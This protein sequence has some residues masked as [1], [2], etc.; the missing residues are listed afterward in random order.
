M[1]VLPVASEVF[2]VITTFQGKNKTDIIDWGT[3]QNDKI[4]MIIF[5]Q[6]PLEQMEQLE[7]ALLFSP[8]SMLLELS[9]SIPR[10]LLLPRMPKKKSRM[11]NDFIAFRQHE[12]CKGKAILIVLSLNSFLSKIHIEINLYDCIRMSHCCR[13][14]IEGAEF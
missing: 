6:L 13:L 12:N 2:F 14:V 8:Q 9:F 1:I 11:G 3:N 4:S 7:K 5:V 10:P